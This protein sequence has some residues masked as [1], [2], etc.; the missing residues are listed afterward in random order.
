MTLIKIAAVSLNT[1]P[2]DFSGN[3]KS[4]KSSLESEEITDSDYVLFPELAISGYGCEDAFYKESVWKRSWASLLEILPYSKDK[5]ILVGL[6]VF[7]SSYL[8]NCIAVLHAG[9]V[10]CL[11]PKMNLA[12]TG[13][14]YEKRWF[15]S[16][17]GFIVENFIPPNHSSMNRGPIP[18]GHFILEKNGI[19]S[20]VEICE[21]SWNLNRPSQY[22]AEN[23]IDVLFSPGASHFAMGKREI[24]KRIFQETSR[25]QRNLAVF[26]NLCGNESGRAIYEGGSLFCENGNVSKEGPRLFF[27]NYRI[28]T[29]NSSLSELRSLRAKE[30]RNSHPNGNHKKIPVLGLT[31]FNKDSS[32][33]NFILDMREK[34]KRKE[35]DY[36]APITVYEDFTRAVSLGLYD[37]LRKSK[38]KGFTL[39]LS[40]GADS[41]IC[42]LLTKSMKELAK[43]ELGDS[44][45]SELGIQE[46]NLLVTL[47]QKTENNST[48]TEKIASLLAKEIGNKHYQVS[49]D[50][51]VTLAV[52]LIESQIGKKL[53]W[54]TDDLA[55]QNIQA[56][57]RSP[58][59]WLLANT[60]GHLLLSTSN[61]SEGSVGYTTMDG[62]SSGSLCPIAGVSKEFLLRFLDDIQ[63]GNNAYI[64]PKESIG[65]L[66]QTKPTAELRPLVTEQEDE[67]DLMPYPILQEIERLLVY[68]GLDEE[69]CLERI[70]EKDNSLSQ[71]TVSKQIER[72][73]RL[74]KVSQWKRER[75]PPSFHLDEYGLDPKTSLRYP[76]L[77]GEF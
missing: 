75:L 10:V 4:I 17:T 26:T 15:H 19:L 32:P 50:S 77:S 68:V 40:G 73:V 64:G 9:E 24:R 18:F 14:H 28:T 48:L 54:E 3:L 70:L 12:N 76:I 72:F 35:S 38:T 44:V 58:L 27:S 59:I 7:H 66:R 46:E 67:K 52:E 11:I 25:I 60:N 2:L 71:D 20:A 29:Y 45:F 43:Q 56:R 42:A 39:S 23:G 1:T 30:F 57:V 41:A 37:Y 22:Y 63:A 21:D 69:E 47:Y 55:L 53:N 74:F 5:T 61:R 36:K 13:I 62:D 33:S 34:E 16:P 65:I 6:P 8:Y 49:I 31:S 51:S